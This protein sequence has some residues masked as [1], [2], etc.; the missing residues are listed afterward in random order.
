MIDAKKRA[1]IT[2]K[3]ENC[4]LELPSVLYYKLSIGKWKN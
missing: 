2:F 1:K 4:E 3:K